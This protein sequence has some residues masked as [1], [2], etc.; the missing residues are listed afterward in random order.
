[1]NA[2]RCGAVSTSPLVLFQIATVKR[3]S[4]PAFMTAAFSV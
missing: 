1:L 4:C 2:S 3:A